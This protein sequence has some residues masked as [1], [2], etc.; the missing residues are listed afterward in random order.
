MPVPIIEIP[1]LNSKD[2]IRFWS[3]ANLT[4]NPERCWEWNAAKSKE[5]YG[6]FSLN[7]KEKYMAHRLAF[8]LHHKKPINKLL[9]C[10][11]CDNPSCINPS[12]LFLG[13]HLDNFKDMKEKGRS[14][15]GNRS[16]NYLYPE[17]RQKGESN[18]SSKLKEH[19]II[20]IR[21]KYDNEN[22]SS[23][24][25][26]NQYGVHETTINNIVKRKKWKHI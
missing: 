15:K 21:N 2:Q 19:Q 5:G 24:E 8:V 13:T 11:T 7:Y 22:M 26:A 18:G 4:A 1:T 25:I 3:K 16:R 20:E 9:V 17:K 23:K 12:H 14:C 10:H 6:R